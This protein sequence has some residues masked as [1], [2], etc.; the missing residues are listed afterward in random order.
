MS[1]TQEKVQ[2]VA[3]RMH[4]DF[5]GADT[6]IGLDDLDLEDNFVW[7]DGRTMASYERGLFSVGDPNNMFDIEHCV[8]V[9]VDGNINKEKFLRD[10]TCGA[11]RLFV[12]ETRFYNPS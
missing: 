11:K 3:Q 2:L 7:A 8:V 12:C 5:D 1:D 6:F 4:D 10:K 9:V